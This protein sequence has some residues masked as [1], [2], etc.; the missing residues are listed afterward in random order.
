MGGSLVAV[1]RAKRFDFSDVSLWCSLHLPP[2]NISLLTT[3]WKPLNK[4]D[5]FD[6]RQQL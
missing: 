1:S 3:Y 4:E 2:V 5:D 6:S